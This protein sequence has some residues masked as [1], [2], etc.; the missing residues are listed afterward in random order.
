MS[1]SL[2]FSL[3]RP[4]SLYNGMYREINIPMFW[5]ET[6]LSDTYSHLSM[7]WNGWWSITANNGGNESVSRCR[8]PSSRDELKSFPDTIYQP[9]STLHHQEETRAFQLIKHNIS[10]DRW[11]DDQQQSSETLT[12]ET[13]PS[14]PCSSSPTNHFTDCFHVYLAA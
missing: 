12:P 14:L 8:N 5:V 3:R 11:G 1:I 9:E 4:G 7:S 10:E 2:H 6:T 13:K